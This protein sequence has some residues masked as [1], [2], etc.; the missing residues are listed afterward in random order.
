M[1][2]LPLQ[3]RLVT[4]SLL[5][6][7]SVITARSPLQAQP[8]SCQ[9]L[10]G[11]AN[12]LA[13]PTSSERFFSA[14]RQQLEQDIHKLQQNPQVQPSVLNVAP[15][16]SEPQQIWQQEQERQLEQQFQPSGNRPSSLL[17]GRHV[18]Q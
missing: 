1:K 15:K 6:L 2:P 16:L 7:A 3:I 9:Q 12:V 17:I 11:I 5:G 13:S 18:I 8:I 10:R 4:I 14:G